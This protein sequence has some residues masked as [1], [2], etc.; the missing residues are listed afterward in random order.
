LDQRTPFPLFDRIFK[1]LMKL[2]SRAVVSFINGLFG[3]RHP[4][5]S[6]VSYP[7]TETINPTLHQS[8]ADM[9]ITINNRYSYLIEA[10]ISGDR[11]MGLRILQYILGEGQRTVSHENPVSPENPVTLIRLPDARVIYWEADNGVPDKETLIFEFP[12]GIR[13]YLEVPSFKFP[14]YSPAELEEMGLGILLPFCL[15]R[16]RRELKEVEKGGDLPRLGEQVAELLKETK[17]A[18]ERSEGRG[19]ISQG[20]LLSV[21]RLIERL[22][23]ELYGG[24]TEEGKEPEMWEDIEL[25][26]YNEIIEERVAR[27][28]EQAVREKEQAAAR[29]LREL[30]VSDE[31]LAAAGLLEA[32]H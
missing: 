16:L 13:Q 17:A 28:K 1:F 2:S 31:L 9:A 19:I 23:D 6:T 12:G 15:L 3:T 5:D 21:L 18:A 8:L 24:Y 25:I 22:R 11:D 27:E 30:G 32:V 14:R 26:N 4:P 7:S 29:K 10:Q 20:D